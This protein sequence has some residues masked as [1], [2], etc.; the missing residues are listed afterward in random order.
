MFVAAVV[1]ETKTEKVFLGEGD[2]LRKQVY[3]QEV[4]RFSEELRIRG[5]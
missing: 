2:K 4:R 1:K 3:H 5:K